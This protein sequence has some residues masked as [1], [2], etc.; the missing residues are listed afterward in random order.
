[1]NKLLIFI[2]L[3]TLA[4]C[5]VE[6]RKEIGAELDKPAKD[7]SYGDALLL[8]IIGAVLAKSSHTCNCKSDKP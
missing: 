4:S 5:S 8:V 2:L 3:L 7:M 6:S 1:M